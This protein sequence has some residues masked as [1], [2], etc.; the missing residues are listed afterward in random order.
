M[1]ARVFEAHL[2]HQQP[3][4]AVLELHGEINA[5]AEDALNATYAAAEASGA[6]TILLNFADVNYINST[7][8]AL[9]VG[10]LARARK[11]HLRLLSCGLSEH[12]V[13]IFTITRLADFM[14]VYPDEAAALQSGAA[15]PPVS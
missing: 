15:Q 5:F 13:E 1:S 9:I 3:R 14:S 2:R 7:G 6:Q 11:S 8:I 10:L 12:Y 4:I